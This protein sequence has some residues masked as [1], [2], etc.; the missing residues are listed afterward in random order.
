MR[1]CILAGIIL[2]RMPSSV[3][4]A[5]QS[6]M[7]TDEPYDWSGPY[8]GVSIGYGWGKS[9]FHDAEYNVALPV[10]PPYDVRVSSDGVVAGLHAGYN[11]QQGSVV[12]GIEGE[13]G[14]LNLKGSAY[15]APDPFGIPYDTRGI[16]KADWNTAITGRLGIASDRTLFFAKGGAAYSGGKFSFVDECIGDFVNPPGCGPSTYDAR[17]T[18]GFGYVLGAG[19]EHAVDDRWSVKLDY[20]YLAFGKQKASAVVGGDPSGGYYGQEKSVEA[21]LTA[22]AVKF[23]INYHF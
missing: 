20:S 9:D 21:D 23:S 16:V 1:S 6:I 12:F 17:K 10:Y 8:A 15:P 14:F 13:V 7:P 11:W 5:E 19:V 18:F 4:A 3:L 22:Q 2:V